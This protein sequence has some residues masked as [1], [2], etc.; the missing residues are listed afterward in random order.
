M[1][2]LTE[3]S[4]KV[5]TRAN[6]FVVAAAFLIFV[7]DKARVTNYR[8]ISLLNV[9][10]K[11]LT[12]ALTIKSEPFMYTLIHDGCVLTVSTG[13]TQSYGIR[14]TSIFVFQRDHRNRIHSENEDYLYMK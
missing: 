13:Y 9:D 7:S 4:E 3:V 6:V 8:P 10:Y 14:F 1:G 5:C 2:V 12:K 11:I